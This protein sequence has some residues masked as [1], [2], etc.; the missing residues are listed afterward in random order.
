LEGLAVYDVFPLDL[1]ALTSNQGVYLVKPGVQFTEAYMLNLLDGAGYQIAFGDTGAWQP[2]ERGFTMKPTK[3]PGLA[4]LKWR[5]V[6]VQPGVIAYLTVWYADTL[7][8]ELI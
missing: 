4:G 3:R 1:S 6:A 2:I 7:D 8:V 5:N